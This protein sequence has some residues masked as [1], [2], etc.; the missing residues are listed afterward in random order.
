V[1]RRGELTDEAWEWIRA[2][3][4]RERRRGGQWKDHRKVVNGILRRI[5]TGAS[6]RDPPARY[7]QTRDD[8]FARWRRDGTRDRLLTHAQMTV[9]AA[10]EVMWEV[11]VDSTV[12]RA[13]HHAARARR[14]ASRETTKKGKSAP[15]TK[16]WGRAGAG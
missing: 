1:A 6:W 9:D 7:G 3:P 16:R 5:R 14:R 11:R 2:S 8:R 15:E 4:A 10:S 12:P 13:H